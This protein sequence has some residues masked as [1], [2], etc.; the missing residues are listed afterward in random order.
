[1]KNRGITLI[2]L[3]ITVIVLL[4]LAGISISMLTGDNSVLQRA[5]ES[6]EKTESS[7][8]QE[9][10]QIAT[11]SAISDGIGQIKD[12]IL[13]QELK[14]NVSGVTDNDITGNEKYGW[15]VK[16]GKKAYSI[17]TTG[18]VNE[19]F[20][21]EVRDASENVTVIKRVDGTVTDLKIGDTINYDATARVK[22]DDLTITSLGIVTGFGEG[23][24][25]IISL[26]DYD[27]TW[28]VLGVENGKLNIVSSKIAGM[29]RSDAKVFRLRGR[30]G[31][32]NA[33]EE[34]NK[35]CG[36]YGKGKYAE[37]ARS[38]NIEDINK[39]TGYD[40]EHT[41]V[42]KN[43]STLEEIT[44][45]VKCDFGQLSQ[46]ENIVTYHWDGTVH[47]KYT[48]NIVSGNLLSDHSH[49]GFIWW[50]G[51]EFQT[52][53]YIE[54]QKGRI[55]ELKSDVYGYYPETLTS[56]SDNSATTGLSYN[57]DIRNMLFKTGSN[58]Y[59]LASRC[60]STLSSTVSYMVR[61]IYSERV[62]ACGLAFSD[63]GQ[64]SSGARTGLRPV[65]TLTAD[66]QLKKDENGIWQFIE[67]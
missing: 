12:S 33:E 54:E 52:F 10:V 62:T 64:L 26:S 49:N 61:M 17:S 16:I 63:G 20:W 18:E 31:Y 42:N 15:Q 7:K 48:S 34:L 24:D 56:N 28:R 25:Q 5:V 45:G 39:L 2:A 67:D 35:V 47:P 29:P 32:K 46:Y 58:G 6:K 13:R 59:W 51:K 53:D 38:I 37:S 40:P 65:V 55:C 3:V 21:E 27:G 11:L 60:V 19:A 50:N 4:I 43:T 57:N 23:R 1:M 22:N 8:M 44:T 36:L 66:I 30:S 9:Q 41:G 14:N